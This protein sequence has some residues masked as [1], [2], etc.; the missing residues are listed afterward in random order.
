M[1]TAVQ[2]TPQQEAAIRR[3]IIHGDLSKLTTEQQEKYYEMLCDACGLDWRFRPFDYLKLN[4]KLV[5]YANKNCGEQLRQN[6]K[7]SI[8]LPEKK[9]E[10]G[11][12]IVTARAE[13]GGRHDEATGAVS[14][15]MLKGEQRANAIMKAETKAKRRVTL[16]FA[17][18][19]MLDETEVESIQG[20]E[21]IIGGSSTTETHAETLTAKPETKAAQAKWEADTARMKALPDDIKEFFKW[22]KITKRDKILSVM[23][24]N[25]DDYDAIR[26]YMKDKG[27]QGSADLSD[28][29]Q[30]KTPEAVA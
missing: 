28:L 16:S 25:H 27:W 5:L 21:K 22:Q 29:A 20:A 10:E 9:I 8:S 14:I 23:D 3:L 2:I 7:I 17:G 30:Q 24:E 12:Y 6:R 18:L 4:G 26:S 1:E 11:V 19:G 15:D 13:S